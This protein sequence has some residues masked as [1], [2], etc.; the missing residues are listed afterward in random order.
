MVIEF[1]KNAFRLYIF[2]NKAIKNIDK[3]ISWT[4]PFFVMW[5]LTVL[6][7]ALSFAIEMIAGTVPTQEAAI[8]GP[9]LLF[10]IIILYPIM[11][12]ISTGI[13]H[14]LLKIVGGKA[15]FL[16]SFKFY[17]SIGIA[18]SLVSIITFLPLSYLSKVTGSAGVIFALLSAIISTAIG[19]WALITHVVVLARVHKISYLRCVVALIVIPIVIFLILLAILV[20][21]GILIG[22][23]SGTL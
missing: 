6:I 9:I 22:I 7:M 14:L 16:D 18:S 20:I 4:T 10:L 2:D 13:L 19:I 12:F 1:F 11:I 21:L 15:K 3:N 5:V 17:L 23:G 8:G